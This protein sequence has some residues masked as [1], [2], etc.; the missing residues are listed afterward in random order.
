VTGALNFTPAGERAVGS[1]AILTFN[2]QN[3]IDE[4]AIQYRIVGG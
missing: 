3:K 1:Y 2:P 4:A